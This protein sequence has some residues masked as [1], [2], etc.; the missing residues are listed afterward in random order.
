MKKMMLFLTAMSMVTISLSQA[1]KNPSAKKPLPLLKNATDSFSYAVGSS[2]ASF[3]KQQGVKNINTALVNK[4]INDALRSASKPLL[5]DDQIQ[6]CISNYI[7]AASTEKASGNIKAGQAFLAANKNKPGVVTTASGLQYLILK[8]GTGPKPAA[9]DKIK[10]HY[11]G[12]LI[13]GRV[14]ESSVDRGQP[15]EYNVNGFIT[16][17]IE[18]LQLMPVGSKWRLFIPSNLAYGNQQ[19]GPMIAAGSTLIFDMEL[20]EILK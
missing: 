2:I 19:S 1:K 12:T 5:S 20:L 14:F 13:D 10:C 17:W 6:S 4:A 3:Y 9:T 8:E 18:A 15:I 11:H 7:Q 16:G